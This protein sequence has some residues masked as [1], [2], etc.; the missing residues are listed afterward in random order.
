MIKIWK[1]G[2]ISRGTHH[3][4]VPQGTEFLCAQRQRDSLSVWYRC[5]AN[6]SF[7]TRRLTIVETNSEAPPFSAKYLGTIQYNDGISVLHIFEERDK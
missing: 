3:V 7:E 2:M 4:S 1:L 5:E 6:N